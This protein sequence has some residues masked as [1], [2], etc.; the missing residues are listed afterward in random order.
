MFSEIVVDDVD[1]QIF[2]S[3]GSLVHRQLVLTVAHA[4]KECVCWGVVGRDW[5]GGSGGSGS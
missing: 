1:L 5:G 4:V 2:T 3:G